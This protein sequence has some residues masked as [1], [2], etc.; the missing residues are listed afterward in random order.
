[1]ISS[2]GTS[3]VRPCADG[4]APVNGQCATAS[5]RAVANKKKR[6]QTVQAPGA[7]FGL[8]ANKD[9]KLCPAGLAACPI[10]GASLGASD[11]YECL[12]AMNDLQSCGG[13]ASL[14]QG[15]DCTAIKGAR[16][17]GCNQGQ[18][19]VYSCR[20][21]FKKVGGNRCERI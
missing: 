18:C 14:G 19:E 8:E 9:A 21:G 11:A 20:A 12:D 3:C 13:C 10:P 5:K 6:A 16:W 1:M 7:I 4:S 2:D 15:Q 17:M